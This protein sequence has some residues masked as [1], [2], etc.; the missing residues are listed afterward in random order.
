MIA[1]TAGDAFFELDVATRKLTW[2]SYAGLE[3]IAEAEENGPQIGIDYSRIHPDD[4]DAVHEAWEGV[5]R[6]NKVDVKFRFAQP[7]RTW[8]WFTMNVAPV[9]AD[10]AD[11]ADQRIR[12]QRA[13]GSDD[14]EPG[15]GIHAEAIFAE[16]SHRESR[17][18]H[19]RVGVAVVIRLEILL[20]I[21]IRFDP[22][23]NND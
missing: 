4:R 11:P 19:V 9:R 6:R 10:P 1:E 16:K 17:R 23:Q 18:N 5:S 20:P 13:R 21:V 8:S 12:S 7:G 2:R 14:P 15:G 22:D 3:H